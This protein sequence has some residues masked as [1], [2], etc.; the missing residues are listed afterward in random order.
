V[1]CVER[2]K[3][4]GFLGGAIVF[5]G[6]KL[7][8][9][10]RDASW[11]AVV[12]PP[13]AP[14]AQQTPFAP[15]DETLRALA[16]AACREALEEAALLPVA[17]G[18]VSHDDLLALRSRLPRDDET[19]PAFLAARHLR[20]D[21]A[22]LH[23]LARWVTPVPEAR[24]FDARF[25]LAVAS[26]SQLGAHDEHE[27]MASFW[28]SPADVLG[29]FANGELQ[30]APPTHRTLDVLSKARSCAEAT[31]IASA[32]CLDPICPR[33]VKHHDANGDALALTLPGDPEHD[34]REARVPGPSRFVLRGNRWLP[35]DAPR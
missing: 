34:V 10:D 26:G 14:R 33:L 7:D 9:R 1:F 22:A 27:T 16:I 2:H 20:L 13:R 8:A 32:S 21:L 6:G 23:P 18:E 17:G 35:E 19:L 31:A 5:P 3:A 28:A 29:R 25:F 4:S 12:T 11:L 15:D 30:L 24:R